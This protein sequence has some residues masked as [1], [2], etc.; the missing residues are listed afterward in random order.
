MRV[1]LSLARSLCANYVSRRGLERAR[2]RFGA[3]DRSID[4]STDCRWCD[5]DMPPQIRD[6]AGD[7]VTTYGA[8]TVDVRDDVDEAIDIAMGSRR[9][10]SRNA[11]WALAAS[12]LITAGVAACMVLISFAL[13]ANADGVTERTKASLHWKLTRE[14]LAK[15]RRGGA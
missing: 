11:A 4:R 15:I 2:G 6:G 5:D 1:E 12:L 13:T 7:G 14:T 10:R 3:I 9:D 8:V